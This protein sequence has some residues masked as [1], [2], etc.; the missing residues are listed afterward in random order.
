VNVGKW[1][2]EALARGYDHTLDAIDSE[3][4]C[5]DRVR[6]EDTKAGLARHGL[7]VSKYTPRRPRRAFETRCY[8][9]EDDATI[10]ARMQAE[11]AAAVSRHKVNEPGPTLNGKP[12]L[13][14]TSGSVI[15]VR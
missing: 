6:F 4:D 13:V 15:A 8:Y 7:D 11:Q 14:R 3:L 9:H 10:I 1:E 12:L 5:I 2:Q